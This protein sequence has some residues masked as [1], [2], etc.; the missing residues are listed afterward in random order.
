MSTVFVRYYDGNDKFITSDNI[1]IPTHQNEENENIMRFLRKRMSEF[2]QVKYCKYY[3]DSNFGRCAHR[4]ENPNF[5]GN[6]I[7]S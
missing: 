1:E 2:Y 4:V 7:K 5:I 3:C 6:S